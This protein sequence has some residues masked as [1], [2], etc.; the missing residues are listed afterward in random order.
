MTKTSIGKKIADNWVD[1]LRETMNKQSIIPQKFILSD[2]SF[3]DLVDW[4]SFEHRLLEMVSADPHIVESLRQ[5][6]PPQFITTL[7]GKYSEYVPGITSC[8]VMISGKE[9]HVDEET[10]KQIYEMIRDIG[11]ELELEKDFDWSSE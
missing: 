6:R 2:E 10:F 4:A 8:Y 1:E 9:Y 7:D 11:V 5:E 3:N